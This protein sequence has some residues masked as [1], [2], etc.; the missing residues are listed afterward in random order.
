MGN[1]K[2]PNVSERMALNIIIVI[3][4]SE[5]KIPKNPNHPPKKVGAE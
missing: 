4:T 5:R 3:T 1:G 2:E